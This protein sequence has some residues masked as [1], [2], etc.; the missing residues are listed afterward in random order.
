MKRGGKWVG[1]FFAALTFFTRI[2]RP[3]RPTFHPDHETHAAA[4]APFIG[5][6]VGGFGASVYYALNWGLPS[7]VAVIGALGAMVWITGATH[8]DGFADFFDGLGGGQARERTLEIM[9]D[10]RIGVFGAISLVLLILAKVL[11]LLELT[12]VI[13]IWQFSVML[14]AAHATS[15]WLAVSYI[16]T[17]TYL[18]A[19]EGFSRAQRLAKPMPWLWFVLASLG[20][21]LPLG[22]MAIIDLKI[23]WVL[24]L[25]WGL[26]QWLARVFSRRLRG[27][28]GD[29]LGA[30]EQLGELGFYVGALACLSVG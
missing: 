13:G 17:H 11:V 5:W 12:R 25:L 1:A 16:Q 24:L 8:E 30:A 18:R 15:R 28:T 23:V 6:L 22:A 19:N 20:A 3:S 26:R 27:Y 4:F 7:S 21:I 9:R 29:C 10:P 2:P 14:I